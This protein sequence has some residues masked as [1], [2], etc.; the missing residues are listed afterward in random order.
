MRIII[1]TLCVLASLGTL[2]SRA[3]ACGGGYGP[4]ESPEVALVQQAV[5]AHFASVRPTCSLSGLS[6]SVD[7]E[8]A[9]AVVVYRRGERSFR[10][11]VALTRVGETWRVRGGEPPERVA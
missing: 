5:A 10:Q 7:G 8:K 1:I 4:L 3:S 9:Q 6:V 11:T 2:E